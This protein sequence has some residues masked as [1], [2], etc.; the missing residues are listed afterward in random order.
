MEEGQPQMI[1]YHELREISPLKAREMI[2]KV[3]ERQGGN[4]SRTARVLGISRH[5]VRRAREGPLEDRSRRPKHSPRKLSTE[6]TGLILRCARRT[7]FRYRR[8][9]RY[10]ERTYSIFISENTIKAILRGEG[11]KP[12]KRRSA[13]GTVRSLY[14]YASL[15][16]FSEFQLDTKYILD[17]GSLPEST[18]RHI[19]DRGLPLYEW[20]LVDVAT[21]ARFTAYSYE[22]TS[23]FGLLFI[24]L[25]GL[26][27]RAHNVRGPIRIRLD[28]GHEWCGGSERKLKDWNEKLK[29]LHIELD[30]I[31]KGAKWQL[32]VIEATH[33]AD[34]EWFLL[35]Y[36]ERCKNPAQFLL[37]AKMWQ[38]TW[39][40]YRPHFGKGMNGMTPKEKLKSTKTM[41][42]DHIL[43]FPVILLE[44]LMTL[45]NPI[46]SILNQP[47]KG[48]KYVY[49]KCRLAMTIRT[50]RENN[51]I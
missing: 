36:A 16:P 50:T 12:R 29:P 42:T 2:L 17:K 20:N 11:L 19:K 45:I 48:G 9:S 44:E 22:L 28:N 32:G 34:D 46:R 15:I 8:L 43:N 25:C 14:D 38:D 10:L 40:F 31:E 30:P 5:T 33:R 24:V 6:L 21:R 3:L 39:N 26:W 23:S 13:K 1:G 41:I 47:Q 35:P 18:Y 51:F 37:K 27:M 7:G 4:V 49:T